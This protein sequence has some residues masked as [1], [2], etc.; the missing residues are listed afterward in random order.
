MNG[1]TWEG[2]EDNKPAND[3]QA[4]DDPTLAWEAQ[5]PCVRAARTAFVVTPDT[6]VKRRDAQRYL[7]LIIDTKRK[8]EGK[9]APWLYEL[10]KYAE[11]G[12]VQ[13]C[14][15][16]ASKIYLPSETPLAGEG[17]AQ[18]AAARTPAEKNP[19]AKEENKPRKK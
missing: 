14:N 9:V 2:P 12:A 7:A 5:G 8:K 13:G 10:A 16:V 6:I 3:L 19:P 1:L 18:D 17:Q 15:D 11:Q 4:M